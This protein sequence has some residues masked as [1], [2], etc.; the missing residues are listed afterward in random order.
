MRRRLECPEGPKAPTYFSGIA[1]RMK[2]GSDGAAGDLGPGSARRV[3]EEWAGH[4]AVD[5]ATVDEHDVVTCEQGIAGLDRESVD[6]RPLS[7]VL[8]LLRE[9]FGEDVDVTHEECGPDKLDR[10]MEFT[11]RRGEKTRL[12]WI[13]LAPADR[14]SGDK[15]L[16]LATAR[17]RPVEPR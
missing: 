6:G 15:D 3:L 5:T 4:T 16:L 9:R 10:T 11:D 2:T 8:M 12:R 17:P 1:A 14:T 7:D 13:A